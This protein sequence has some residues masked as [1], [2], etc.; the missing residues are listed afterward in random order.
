MNP[1]TRQTMQENRKMQE[2]E[3]LEKYEKIKM[4]LHIT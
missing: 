3:S 2:D 1:S 4:I